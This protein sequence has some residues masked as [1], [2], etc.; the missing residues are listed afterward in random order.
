MPCLLVN[1]EKFSS[2]F[3]LFDVDGT[4]V[5]D[6]DRYKALA[7]LRFDAIAAKAG[8]KAAETWAPLGGWDFTTHKL[9][10]MGPIA[11][12]ARREDMA[13]AAVAIYRTGRDWHEARALAEAAYADADTVQMR[14]YTPTLFPGVENSLRKLKAAGFNLGIAT[15]GSNKITQELLGILGIQSLFS[16][17]VGSEDSSNPKP[18]PDLL[19]AAC[20]KANVSPF[21]TIYV[22]D[23]PVDAEAARAAGC[24]RSIIV[25]KASISPSPEVRHVPSVTDLR[26]YP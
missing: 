21:C 4:L 22:G 25:G 3:L 11:K 5:D 6:E 8:R 23:Q 1:G 18:A 16:V 9:D 10:M 2:E 26:V 12:A 20:T 7:S 13:I 19:L 14:D 15:N 24:M 17:V